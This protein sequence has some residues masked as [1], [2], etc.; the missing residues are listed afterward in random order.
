MEGTGYGNTLCPSTDSGKGAR[1]PKLQS[2][3]VLFLDHAN[4]HDRGHFVPKARALP[5]QRSKNGNCLPAELTRVSGLLVKGMR[6][7]RMILKVN[8]IAWFQTVKV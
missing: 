8:F 6:A 3:T 1:A 5:H 7:L 4:Q 2:L